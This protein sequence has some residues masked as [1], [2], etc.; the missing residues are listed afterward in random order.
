MIVLQSRKGLLATCQLASGILLI[1]SMTVFNFQ[2]SSAQQIDSGTGLKM[3]AG[4]VLVQAACTKCHSAQLVTQNSGTREVWK[5]RLR[6]MQEFQGL[7][8]L[9]T[10][11]E[12][13]ILDYLASNYGQKEATRRAG[14]ATVLM[15]HNP[16]ETLK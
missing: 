7:A 15:P 12:D 5:S 2:V 8:Q 4:W 6:W 9:S 10:A 16:Y 11:V 3:D 1:S 14:I 13:S